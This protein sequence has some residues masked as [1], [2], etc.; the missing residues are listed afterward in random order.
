MKKIIGL[1]KKLK[2]FKISLEYVQDFVH[3]YG[4]KIYYE[5]FEKLITSYVD[6]EKTALILGQVGYEQL[7]Y[8]IDIPA[9]TLKDQQFNTF[10]GYILR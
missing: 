8:D 2:S 4:L 9:P 5:Q 1:S 7:N 3:I 10:L 6:M